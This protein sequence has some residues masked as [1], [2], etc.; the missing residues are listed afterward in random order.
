MYA[1]MHQTV[2]M[3][4]AATMTVTAIGCLWLAL[5]KP[6]ARRNDEKR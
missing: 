1:L 2:F 4:I 3:I 5:A 6:G